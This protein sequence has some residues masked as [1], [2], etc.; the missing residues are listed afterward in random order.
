MESV[1]SR[2]LYEKHYQNAIH[3]LENIRQWNTIS[4]S[5]RD[6]LNSMYKIMSEYKI[7]RH[8]ININLLIH[9]AE[10]EK[11]P[12][13]KAKIHKEIIDKQKIFKIELEELYEENKLTQ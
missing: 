11:C 6:D 8:E 13:E 1:D 2:E 9:K 12:V 4:S 7:K 10:S 5:P 3:T